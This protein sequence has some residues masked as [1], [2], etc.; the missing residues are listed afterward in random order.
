MRGANELLETW[1]TGHPS[2]GTHAR[3]ALGVLRRV[4]Q[5]IQ[6]AVV[7]VTRALIAETINAIACC[8]AAVRIAGRRSFP[9]S[10]GSAHPGI[11]PFSHWKSTM[12]CK[13]ALRAGVALAFFGPLAAPL[14][15]QNR[16]I[17]D[18]R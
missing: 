14:L 13:H 5:L 15:N 10:P 3:T 11:M 16:S 7:T 8:P 12:S 6:E 2:I 1:S 9:A 18:Q 17:G 4:E